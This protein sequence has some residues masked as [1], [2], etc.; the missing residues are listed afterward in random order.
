M[1]IEL[2]KTFL[3]VSKTRHFGR[4]AENLFLTPAAVSARIRLLESMLGARVLSRNRNNIQLTVEG[5]RLLPHCETMLLAWS[6]ARQE[7]ALRP[8]QSSQL[9][10]GAT[11]G[12]WSYALQE[13]WQVIH[14]TMPELAL[15]AEAHPHN[16][17][18]EMLRN[19]TL[20][21][22]L[23]YEPVS[24][25]EL[26]SCKIG[27]IQLLLTTSLKDATLKNIRKHPYVYV[28]WG[29]AFELFHAK[30]FNTMANTLLHTNMGS[31]ALHFIL[32]NPASAF[33]PVSTER[34]SSYSFQGSYA[35][36]K[37]VDDAPQFE[38]SLYATYHSCSDKQVVIKKVMALLA[39]L[40]Y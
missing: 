13:Q 39:E 5:E 3:E 4:A 37:V 22:A 27:R 30:K 21:M 29:T 8:E 38:R 10:L 33:L 7:V 15:R 18:V 16:Y 14:K 35:Q 26:V 31:V 2:L 19:R 23:L 32:Q 20:D 17:L 1:D 11:Y 40:P 24:V 34:K 36:L 25:N 28:D 12:L 9:S 6:R